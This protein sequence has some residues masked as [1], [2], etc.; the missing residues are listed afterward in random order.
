MKKSK[1]QIRE[2][3]FQAQMTYEVRLAEQRDMQYW[4]SVSEDPNWRMSVLEN[5]KTSK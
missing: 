5:K 2:E 1:K 3:K 4:K